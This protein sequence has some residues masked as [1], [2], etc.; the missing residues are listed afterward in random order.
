MSKIVLTE[1]DVT[2]TPSTGK[3]NLYVKTDGS[4]AIRDDTGTESV[5]LTSDAIGS[6][7]QAYD[8]D[9]PTVAA[10]QAEMEA[11]TETALRSMSPA[12][13]A[14]AISAL[15]GGGS[16]GAVGI[17][18]EYITGNKTLTVANSG[19]QIVD[20]ANSAS[21]TLTL[22]DATTVSEGTIMFIIQNDSDYTLDV[23]NDSGEL[24]SFVLKNQIKGISLEDN[25]S[26]SGIWRKTFELTNN[27]GLSEKYSVFESASSTYVSVTTLSSTQALVCYTDGG[28]SSYGTACILNIS[29]STI[30]P[31]IPVV[32]ESASTQFISVTTLSSNQALVCYQDTGNSSYGTACILDISGSTITPAT[33]VVFESARAQYILV[34]TLSSTQALVCYR[35]DINSGFGT[36]CVLDISGSTITPETPV[37][38]ESASTS[39]ISAT[40]LSSNQALVC[41]R[42]TGNSSYGTACVLDISGSTIT[43]ATPVV[44]ESASSTY[45]SVTTLSST[46]AL[47]CYTDGGNS[48]RGTAC[49][50]DISGSTIT[51]A[52]PVVFES[53]STT[54]ISVTTLPSNQALVCYT[55]GGNS[56]YGTA[57]IL[58]ISGSTITT[59]VPVVFESA[60]TTYISVTTLPSNQAL[61]CYQDVGNSNYGTSTFLSVGI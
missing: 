37:V 26:S 61:V 21:Y 44:F 24:V 42:D 32:F 47:V 13:V 22:P 40:T 29:G 3:S 28:N 27:I 12:N 8:A 45:V 48:N 5:V 19:Y 31:A 60:S 54:Y 1:E 33:P 51:P 15:G 7:V 18:P 58:D 39:E 14:Q 17:A 46:Q 10:S 34:T 20:A 50:L 55:D 2:N 6:T 4:L 9:I 30:T 59:N 53:A 16:A 49:V 25:S 52:T 36:A 57:C 43:P 23:L 35:D 41:Y 11:G 56:S 38:F